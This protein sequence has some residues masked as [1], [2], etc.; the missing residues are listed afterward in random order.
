MKNAN[1]VER[2]EKRKR[3]KR[4]WKRVGIAFLLYA[5]LFYTVMHV[6]ALIISWRHYIDSRPRNTEYA[7]ILRGIRPGMT[8]E[9]VRS[10]LLGAGAYIESQGLRFEFSIVDT[11]ILQHSASVPAFGGQ[12]RL[13]YYEEL[14]SCYFVNGRIE[15]VEWWRTYP[16]VKI[17]TID[18]KKLQKEK[19]DDN[20]F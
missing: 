1:E 14:Y 12:A 11:Y 10:L 15:K 8:R 18:F 20:G 5:T 16:S 4:F 17:V 7:F 9:E 2:A 19:S 3:R 6:V 13:V